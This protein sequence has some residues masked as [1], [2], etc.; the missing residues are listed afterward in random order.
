MVGFLGAENHK[1][2]EIPT[3]ADGIIPAELEEILSSWPP[4]R[5]RP[6]V[7]YT[8]PTGSNPTGAT[9]PESRKI[10]MYVFFLFFFFYDQGS[11]AMCHC[12]YRAVC[13]VGR[14][15]PDSCRITDR[16]HGLAPLS[17]PN[18]RLLLAQRFDFVIFED[19]AYYYLNYDL[20]PP[21]MARNYLGLEAEVTG[22]SGRVVRFDSLSKVV[23]SGM[24]IGFLT[25]SR[26]VVQLVTRLTENT[27]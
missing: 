5:P 14:K 16:E 22:A 24:R 18:L 25:G 1:L 15:P 6:K 12:G 2:I 13:G 3:D 9:C 20:D 7:L 23:S 19:N 11:S 27:K 8:S 10:E 4:G 17:H 26:Q 21:S